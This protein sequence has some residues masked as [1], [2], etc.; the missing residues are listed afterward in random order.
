MKVCTDACLFGALS[1]VH[2]ANG[3]T[4]QRVLDIGTGTGLLSLQ[5]A[6][7]NAQAQV[8]AVEIDA[9]AYEQAAE[10]F[11]ASP[12]QQRLQVVHTPLQQFSPAQLYQLVICNPPFFE[13]DL[14]SVDN[15]RN[16]ALHSEA[17]RLEEL[18]QHS[19]ALLEDEGLLWLLLPWHRTK[20][21]MEAASARGF[22]LH[23]LTEV[24]QTP[25][26]PYFRSMLLFGKQ[27]QV[28]TQNSLCIKDAENQYT[29]AFTQDLQAFYLYL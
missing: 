4:I 2:N 6:Q 3:E 19:Y 5:Y 25:R 8:T 17:L 22:T 1:P 13:N 28:T 9:G 15:K 14:K 18:L 12:W 7:L 26:H 16:L 20:A 11:A 21:A 29:P 24:Q 23:R 27:P 10:N